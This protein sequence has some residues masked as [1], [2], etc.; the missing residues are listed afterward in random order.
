MRKLVVELLSNR[1]GIVLATINLVLLADIAPIAAGPPTARRI[2]VDLILLANFPAF[3]AGY[4]FAEIAGLVYRFHSD[5]TTFR[6]IVSIASALQWLLIA[7]FARK[8][9]VRIKS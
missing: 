4:I 3:I 1:L 7:Q 8:M 2:L 5:L 9:A 6:I